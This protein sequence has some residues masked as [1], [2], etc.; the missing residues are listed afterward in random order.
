M[1]AKVFRQRFKNQQRRANLLTNGA[2]TDEFLLA[3]F[4]HSIALT[5]QAIECDDEASND[6]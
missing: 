2:V 4:L 6:N 1:K 5:L 3:T